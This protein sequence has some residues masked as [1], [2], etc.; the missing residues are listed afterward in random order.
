MTRRELQPADDPTQGQYQVVVSFRLGR[1]LSVDGVACMMLHE[2]LRA[3][4]SNHGG[5][6][7]LDVAVREI[8]ADGERSVIEGAGP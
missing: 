1:P 6:A 5:L 8:G 7:D 3:W 4:A 2:G